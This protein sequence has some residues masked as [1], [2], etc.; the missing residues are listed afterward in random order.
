M[1]TWETLHENTS[2]VPITTGA[3]VE[4]LKWFA[5][6]TRARHEKK[7]DAQL[8]EKGVQSFLP[9]SN[10][11]HQWSDRR[12]MVSQPLFPGYLFV[13]ISDAPDERRSVLTTSGVCW[14]VG[15]QGMGLPIPGKQIQDI[16]TILN[17]AAP[18]TP[19]PFL[20]VGQR[21]RI[22]GGCL[23]GI[24]GILLSKD[25]D[26]TVVVSVE[27]VRRS[28]AVPINGYDLEEA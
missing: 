5:I 4:E 24:E 15:N 20:R 21:V 19:F 16:Q 6:Q 14:F 8:H 9:L 12:K 11:M 10:E 13:Q 18:Y 23:D 26:R 2:A 22:R 28:L 25:S 3:L 7:V 17:S 27:L 1:S